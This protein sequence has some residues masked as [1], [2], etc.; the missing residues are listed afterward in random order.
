MEILHVN[1]VFKAGERFTED[2][3]FDVSERLEAFAAV[4]SVAQ[5]LMGGSIALT[6]EASGLTNAFET[7]RS[8]VVTTLQAEGV[9]ATI[10]SVMVQAESEFQEEL[11][12]PVYPEVVGFA[13]I[14]K[15]VGVSRQRIR[16][17]TEK[18]SFPRPVIRTGQGPLYTVHAVN[19]WAETRS[20]ANHSA[21]HSATA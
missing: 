19:R 13:E 6:V 20:A 11:R 7:A 3:A 4:M 10:T 16:Q 18:P 14:A 21:A 15:I 8:A 12:A 9:D 17:L 5:D 2:L 1:I